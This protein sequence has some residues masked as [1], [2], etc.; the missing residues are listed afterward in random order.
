MMAIMRPL[1]LR[2]GR[3]WLAWAGRAPSDRPGRLA[4]VARPLVLLGLHLPIT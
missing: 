4:I 2:S 3:D 1:P